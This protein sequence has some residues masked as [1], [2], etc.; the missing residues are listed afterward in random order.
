[1]PRARCPSGDRA[2][3]FVPPESGGG[4]GAEGGVLGKQVAHHIALH[5]DALPP[6]DALNGRGCGWWGRARSLTAAILRR[7]WWVLEDLNL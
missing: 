2:S 1:M 5:A 4:A 7:F 3:A 6:D